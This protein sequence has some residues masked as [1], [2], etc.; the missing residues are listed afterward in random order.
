MSRRLDAL[1]A[2][3][4]VGRERDYSPGGE[5]ERAV[6]QHLNQTHPKWEY[7]TKIAL[8]VGVSHTRLETVLWRMLRRGDVQMR[9]DERGNLLWRAR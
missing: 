3:S 8:A 1:Q 6:R 9:K 7:R 2:L 4:R 5:V